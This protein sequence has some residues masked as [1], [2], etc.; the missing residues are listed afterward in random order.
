MGGGGLSLVWGSLQNIKGKTKSND[1]WTW[2][3]SLPALLRMHV[4]NHGCGS[5]FGCSAPMSDISVYT[6]HVDSLQSWH[7]SVTVI[8]TD[9]IW[10]FAGRMLKM[11]CKFAAHIQTPPSVTNT[12]YKLESFCCLGLCQNDSVHDGTVLY[13][14]KICMHVNCLV[15]QQW[16]HL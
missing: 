9:T 5:T 3:H 14:E 13:L 4:R 11:Q 1:K 6:L 2:K 15:D 8:K 7:I 10:W 12:L 16:G